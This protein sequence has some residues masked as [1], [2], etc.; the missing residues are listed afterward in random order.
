[1]EIKSTFAK[2]VIASFGL[3]TSVKEYGKAVRSL[4]E[5]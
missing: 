4:Q 5:H 2:G 1:M 3:P